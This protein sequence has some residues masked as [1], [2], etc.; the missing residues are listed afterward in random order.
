MNEFKQL[1]LGQISLAYYAAAAFFCGLAILLSLYS[2]SRTRDKN[3]RN[4]PYDFSWRFLLWDN[5]KRVVTGLI[6]MFLFFRFS[7]E[8]FGKPLTMWWAV[9]IGFFLSFGLDK[10]I[11]FIQQ[12]YDILK[13]PRS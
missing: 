13:M 8:I 5:F 6:L 11:Q 4:T 12:K 3:S 7:P 2:H 1:I 9:G 10:A